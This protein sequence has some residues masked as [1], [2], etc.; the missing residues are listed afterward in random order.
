MKRVLLGVLLTSLLVLAFSATASAGTGA[1]PGQ[2]T[3]NQL[4]LT[5]VSADPALAPTATTVY[6]NRF[7][8]TSPTYATAVTDVKFAVEKIRTDVQL[9]SRIASP[10]RMERHGVKWDEYNL[11]VSGQGFYAQNAT[12][13]VLYPYGVQQGMSRYL[14]VRVMVP[15]SGWN[16]H[17]FF[18]HHGAAD[19]QALMYSPVVEPELLLSRGWA[20]AEAQFNGVVPAQQNPNATDDSYWKSVDEMFLADPNYYSSYAVHPD[21]FSNPN[22][23]AIG[24][25][26]TLRNLTGLVKNLLYLEEG[27]QP[28]RTYWFGWSAGGPAGTALDTGCD[29]YGNFTGGDFNVP[30]DKSSGKV[31][32]AFVALEPVYYASATVDPQFPIVAPFVFLDGQV[33]PLSLEWPNALGVAHKVQVALAGSKADP[34]LSKS[35]NDWVHLYTSQ[36][37]DHDWTGRFFA[38][39]YN[40]PTANEHPVWYDISKPWGERFNTKGQGRELNWEMTEL[41]W[42]SPSY[43]V[44]WFDQSM[45]GWGQ[46]TSAYYLLNDGYHTAIFNDL[47]DSV[48]NGIAMPKSRIDPYLLAGA[49]PPTYYPGLPLNDPTQD[50]LNTNLTARTNLNVT[51]AADLLWQRTD[52]NALSLLGSTVPLPYYTARWGLFELGYKWWIIHPFTPDQLVNGYHVGNVDFAGYANQSAFATA[53][54]N[55]IST[56]QSQRL[57]DPQIAASFANGDPGGPALTLP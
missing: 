41:Y 44:D 48:E 18:W 49:T 29:R 47:V 11:L 22:G 7:S 37:G 17:L 55:A 33:S 32:D 43:L 12:T 6:Q 2:P 38:T 23:V 36:Y 9:W 54:Q 19:T 56:L 15:R 8:T 40:A 4:L 27:R 42:N 53:F 20:V 21:W 13:R 50:S 46:G 10:L 26:A 5:T 45:A 1:P 35:I 16:G 25:G 24:D 31:F 51:Q 30:Y 57:Y 39:V 28:S 3:A 52:P 14:N 34:S